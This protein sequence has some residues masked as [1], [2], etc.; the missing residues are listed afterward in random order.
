MKY[1]FFVFSL[2]AIF[3]CNT[4]PEKDT[5]L[6]EGVSSDLATLRKHQVSDLVYHLSFHIPLDKEES[7]PS[8]LELNL[9]LNDKK[10]HLYLDFNEDKSNL[11]KVLANGDSIPVNHQK[12]HLIIDKKY[13]KNGSNIIVVVF[14]AGEKS[15]NRNEDYLYTLLVPDRASTLFPCFDQPDL[16]AKYK[17]EITAPKA[18]NVLTGA[19]LNQK[20]EGVDFTR[21]VYKMS[22]KMSTYLFSF[23]AGVFNEVE[24]KPRDRAMTL[25]FRENDEAKINA[26]IDDIF[27]LHQESVEFLEDYTQY[28]FP[29]QKMDFASIPGFQYGGMEHVGAIQYRE[30]SLFLD[31]STTQERLLN[32]ARLIAHETSHMWYGDLV[33]MKWF[34]DVWLKEVFA[35]FIADKIVKGSFPEIN[36]DLRFLTSHYPSAYSE[37]RTQGATPIRQKLNNLKNAGTLYGNIIYHKAPIMM[38]QLEA[39]MGEQPF[40]NGM[41]NY[42][43]K[44]A[45]DNADWND[46]VD[47]LDKETPID[48]NKWSEIW[49]NQSGRPLISDSI[50]YKGGKIDSFEIYQSAEDG[51]D[52]LWAQAFDLGL[53][54]KD[55]VH[56]VSVNI[57]GRKIKLNKVKGMPKPEALIYNYN[58]LGYGVFPIDVSNLRIIDIKDEVARG[59]CYI[60]LYENMLNGNVSPKVTLNELIKGFKF[61]DEDL[62]INL[63]SRKIGSVFWKYLSAN[64]R[65]KMLEPLET[66]LKS[67]LNENLSPS[68]KKTV[69]YLYQSIAYSE[70][71]KAFLYDIWNKTTKIDNLRLNENDYTGLATTLAIYNHEKAQE[72]LNQAQNDITN[73]DRKERFKFLLPA[74]S[75]S[76][77]IRDGFMKSLS[78]PE[79]REKESWVLSALSYIHHPLRQDSA[80]KHLRFCLDLVEEIQRTGDIFFPKAWLDATIGRYSS[81]DAYQVLQEFLNDNPDFS[82]VLKNKLLQSTDGLYRAQKIRE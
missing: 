25:L 77:S 1:L 46:L 51:K 33:T 31:E 72:I 38:R 36:H 20:E 24:K 34:D 48:L 80:K 70:G 54:Y 14:D 21:H 32:R 11:K 71:G 22:D 73:T 45:N 15:L 23:V 40:N 37:D 52:K 55:S 78:K 26:S 53:I 69:F 63:V 3:S 50:T 30:S 6:V 75:N 81:E 68:I 82:P 2:I 66:I 5:L 4:K 39:I 64:D 41:R 62:I 19:A 44:Y 42:I 76:E 47:L 7:I 49:V 59:Y 12:E 61:E 8:K 43:K 28:D 10:N 60:N 13:L 16:K 65:E 74:L 56:M 79:N 67:R 57:K 35:N 9:N 29:F 58:G 27:N 17:L 18:W